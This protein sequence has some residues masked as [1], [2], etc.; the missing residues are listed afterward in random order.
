LAERALVRLV[1]EYGSVPEFV[2]LGGLLPDLLCSNSSRR[3]I[4]TTDVDV[5]VNLE[6][7]GGCVN[8][9]RLER[10]L[11]TVGFKPD[12]ERVW[13]WK[14]EAAPAMVV[15][16]EFLAD[17]DDVP[18][19]L[20]VSFSDCQSLGAQNLRGTGF[21]A[22]D[23]EIQTIPA[24]IDGQV[25]G[26][27]V[28]VATLPAYLLTKAHAAHGRG[29]TKDWYDIAYVL[30]HNDAGGPAASASLV[31]ERFGDSLVGSTET[32]LSELAANFTDADSQGSKAYAS[33]MFGMYPDLDEDVLA[34]NAVAAV[35]T[36]ISGLGIKR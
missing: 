31:R 23:W 22:K 34:N 19:Q 8:S 13:R 18:N 29:L 10:A 17:I 36:F 15:K 35:A 16:I 14:D 30:L 24:T 2:L 6:I 9:A 11:L 7:Q 12:S 5:Q 3:H 25:V 26:A 27:E 28:R 20:S 1:S 32:A 4:G 21:A 33:T